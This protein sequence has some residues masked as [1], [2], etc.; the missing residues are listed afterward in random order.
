MQTR[1]LPDLLLAYRAAAL[2]AERPDAIAA[3]TAAWLAA[4]KAYYEAGGL[5][6]ANGWPRFV[7]VAE[8]AAAWFVRHGN[9][10]RIDR[11]PSRYHIANWGGHADA[12]EKALS[13][14]PTRCDLT[15]LEACIRAR[16]AQVP[17]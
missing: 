10:D 16:L 15:R 3:D 1:K 12:I 11:D 6:P 5:D 7:Q 4:Q 13:R 8:E 17:A 2:R 14:P 9:F